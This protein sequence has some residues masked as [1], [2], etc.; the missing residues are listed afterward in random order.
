[1]SM[2]PTLKAT[3]YQTMYVYGTTS[4]H[5][6]SDEKHLRT[7]DKGVATTFE[8]ECIFRPND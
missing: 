3:S 8:L 7:Y 4:L 1:M 2:P 6:S 5:V